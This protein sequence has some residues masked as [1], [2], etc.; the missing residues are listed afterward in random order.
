MNNSLQAQIE[1]LSG[2]YQQG[3]QIVSGLIAKQQSLR[4]ELTRLKLQF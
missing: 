2:E 4:A 3:Q 1:M